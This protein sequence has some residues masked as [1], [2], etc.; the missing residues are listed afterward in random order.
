M[1]IMKQNPITVLRRPGAADSARNGRFA[2]CRLAVRCLAVCAAL[3][4]CLAPARAGDVPPVA[5]PDSRPTQA[6]KPALPGSR[7]RNGALQGLCAPGGLAAHYGY[8][9]HPDRGRRCGEDRPHSAGPTLSPG[10]GSAGRA[11][12]SPGSRRR[13]TGATALRRTRHPLPTGS[14]RNFARPSLTT[15]SSESN[16]IATTRQPQASKP[17]AMRW[18]RCRRVSLP[19][20]GSYMMGWH[21]HNRPPSPGRPRRPTCESSLGRKWLRTIPSIS[22][23]LLAGCR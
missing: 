8:Q 22:R 5:E 21:G 23:Y 17:R 18:R 19:K 4:Q 10:E 9:Q 15:G 11:I 13:Q 12:P 3:M 6:Q 20:R 7:P 1:K 2:L 16:G 14:L